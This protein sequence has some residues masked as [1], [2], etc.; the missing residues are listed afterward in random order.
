[1]K[2]QMTCAAEHVWEGTCLWIAG[3]HG[4]AFRSNATVLYLLGVVNIV[5]IFYESF[6]A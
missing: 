4:R 3:H 5:A 2:G 1:M 6:T